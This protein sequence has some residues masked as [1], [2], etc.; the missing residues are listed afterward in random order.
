MYNQDTVKRVIEGDMDAFSV[1]YNDLSSTVYRRVYDI[2][3]DHAKARE[4]VRNVFLDI[5]RHCPQ[6]RDS[7]LFDEWLDSLIEFY[8]GQR[9]QD[10]SMNNNPDLQLVWNDIT[11]TIASTMQIKEA[12]TTNLMNETV[13][14]NEILSLNTMSVLEADYSLEQ[15]VIGYENIMINPVFEINEDIV[16]VNENE[17][18]D[19]NLEERA[20][21]E[22]R[23]PGVDFEVAKLIDQLQTEDWSP[24]LFPPDDE[25]DSM[26]QYRQP[27]NELPWMRGD[28]FEA[29][30]QN[31]ASIDDDIDAMLDEVEDS[32]RAA[33]VEESNKQARDAEKEALIQ[34]EFASDQ[35][36]LTSSMVEHE[37]QAASHDTEQAV[38]ENE[39]PDI[40]SVENI[41]YFPGN[42]SLMDKTAIERDDPPD[43]LT[44]GPLPNI[45]EAF[46]AKLDMQL[47]NNQVVVSDVIVGTAV[48]QPELEPFIE[49]EPDETSD[50]VDD[51]VVDE[52]TE[53]T[54]EIKKTQVFF[55]SVN[56]DVDQVNS[57]ISYARVPYEYVPYEEASQAIYN[58]LNEEYEEQVFEKEEKV[59]P[60]KQY[61]NVSAM[62][63]S[64]YR[65][66]E[67]PTEMESV[68]MPPK[69]KKK[70]TGVVVAIIVVLVAVGGALVYAKT[71]GLI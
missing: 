22:E 60:Q 57:R 36:S 27:I 14:N 63:E 6:L 30:E 12:N 4:V 47:S 53:S 31:E 18:V 24:I 17:L 39:N 9:E 45:D 69:V 26:H 43:W 66:H 59:K 15:P 41:M 68:S 46:T 37:Q 50:E 8:S 2:V 44:S 25:N 11:A 62:K 34:E 21:M 71:N 42:S 5:H 29:S 54:T 16:L 58:R 32:L 64:S 51:D 61:Q 65:V 48:L 38:V 35:S 55:E 19:V 13:E 10:G 23:F 52:K 56:V 7:S 70:K 67:A 49:I 20:E 3:Q 1:M 28:L 33:R 40:Q